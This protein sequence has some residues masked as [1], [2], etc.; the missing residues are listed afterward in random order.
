[1]S[2]SPSIAFLYL[3]GIHHLYHSAMTAVELSNMQN[4]Y[5]IVLVSCSPEHTRLLKNIQSL[6]PI[7]NTIIKEIPL[8]F[9]FKYLNIKNKTYPSPSD[10][11]PKIAPYLRSVDGIVA[12]SHS[13]VTSAKKYGITNP[14]LIYQYHG[15][16][17]RKYGFEPNLGNY[18]LLLLPGAYHQQRLHDSGVLDK[19]NTAIVGWP[20]LDY[21][22]DV[23]GLKQQLFPNDNPI[24]LY[25]PHWSPKLSS[26]EAWC[27]PLMDYFKANK[28]YNFLFAP[29]IQLKH[30]KNKYNYD[31]NFDDYKVENIHIDLGSEAGVNSSYLRIANIYMGDV[32]SQI[33][34]W[35]ALNPR[36]CIFTNA[37]G[38]QWE[39]DINYRH[40]R[41]GPVMNNI[42]ELKGILQLLIEDKSYIDYQK[43]QIPQYIDISTDKYSIRAAEA[44]YN[45]VSK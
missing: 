32:S 27:R 3:H 20:K 8:P 18:D 15:C 33:Y 19:K 43:N 5:K 28:E 6:Y 10:T 45:F 41:Y 13:T 39:D 9:R 38:I 22:V 44:I 31:L 40:W 11:M 24:I 26:F 16:G 4:K 29:H 23:T 17:D 35:I 30:W 37:H 2:S 1:M 14:K 42:S 36:P 7:Q 21:P 12:T 34:E 25:T